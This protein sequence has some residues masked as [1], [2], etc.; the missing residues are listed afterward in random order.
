MESL[1]SEKKKKKRE[2]AQRTWCRAKIKLR[3]NLE[4]T[5]WR[6]SRCIKR[7]VYME[8]TISGVGL[9]RSFSVMLAICDSA[10]IATISL[11]GS[12]GIV[13]F[14]IWFGA[15]SLRT[16]TGRE[17][18]QLQPRNMKVSR[19]D[20]CLFQNC[21]LWTRAGP[22][23]G[24]GNL[25][26]PFRPTASNSSYSSHPTPPSPPPRSCKLISFSCFLF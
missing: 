17:R 9:S 3:A 7:A 18:E 12:T 10:R 20:S 8:D 19:P 23:I 6:E 15:L 11:R 24:S 26:T 22:A 2:G 13:K 14:D 4:V 21:I 16:H 1:T 5:Y 25:S